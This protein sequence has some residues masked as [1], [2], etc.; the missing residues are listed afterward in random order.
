M[1]ILIF[2]RWSRVSRK[3]QWFLFTNVRYFESSNLLGLP[4]PICPMY[5]NYRHQRKR[6]NFQLRIA[7]FSQQDAKKLWDQNWIFFGVDCFRVQL[8]GHLISILWELV[9]VAVR[10]VIL[11]SYLLKIWRP[12]SIFLFTSLF[13]VIPINDAARTLFQFYMMCGFPWLILIIACYELLRFLT[14][15]SC[16]LLRVEV[17]LKSSLPWIK[18]SLPFSCAR[19]K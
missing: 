1:S 10:H 13:F 12:V 15:I 8:A 19:R 9:K 3:F 2:D 6:L 5:C 17:W 7:D 11:N 18:S 16:H 14:N 4:F